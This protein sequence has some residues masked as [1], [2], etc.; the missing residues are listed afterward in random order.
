MWEMR[1]AQYLNVLNLA[2][3]ENRSSCGS[4]M[5]QSSEEHE[6]EEE[7]NEEGESI[8]CCA[9]WTMGNCVRFNW[10]SL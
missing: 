4:M 9:C 1:G 8:L 5:K 7:E 3:S 10:S 2:A 6:N